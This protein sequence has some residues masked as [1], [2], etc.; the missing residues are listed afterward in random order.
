MVVTI[1]MFTREKA[2]SKYQFGFC[3]CATNI[4]VQIDGFDTRITSMQIQTGSSKSLNFP[5][6]FEQNMI[7]MVSAK[8]LR[9]SFHTSLNYHKHGVANHIDFEVYMTVIVHDK[10]KGSF[11]FKWNDSCA[12]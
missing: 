1:I 8:K 11:V 6:S 10:G 3:L 12:A 2:S 7:I 4:Y 9:H 5:S